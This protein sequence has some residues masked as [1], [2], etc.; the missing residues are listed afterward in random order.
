MIQKGMAGA[1]TAF[2]PC[3]FFE[4]L[5]RENVLWKPQPVLQCVFPHQ[6]R[7]AEHASAIFVVR[8]KRG[9]M[10]LTLKK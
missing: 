7:N 3:R 2:S 9:H 6:Q 10:R 4:M 5:R 1:R 8:N